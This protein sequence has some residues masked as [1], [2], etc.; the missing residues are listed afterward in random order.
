MIHLHRLIE[1]Q[2]SGDG[3]KTAFIS[4]K[5]H[6]DYRETDRITKELA[7]HL[8][9]QTG[10]RDLLALWMPNSPE[11]VFAYLAAFRAYRVPMPIHFGST[12]PEVSGMLA[13]AGAKHLIVAGGLAEKEAEEWFA[14]TSIEKLWTLENYRLKLLAERGEKHA[15]ARRKEGIGQNTCLILHTSGSSG[16]SKGVVLSRKSISHVIEGRVATACICYDSFAVVA[17]SLSHSVGLYQVLALLSQGASFELLSGYDY[18]RM[19]R[20][21]NEHHPSH[22]IMVVSAFSQLLE[23]P[24]INESSFRNIVFASVGADR[25]TRKV[26]NKYR[27]LTGEFLSVSYGMT[28]YSWILVNTEKNPEH[29]LALGRPTKSTRVELRDSNGNIVPQGSTGEIFV[30]GGNTMQG[31]LN[32]SDLD[33]LTI[34]DGWIRSGD[35]AYQDESGSYWFVGRTT[36]LIVLSSGDNVSPAEIENEI[37]AFPGI[38]DC[39]VISM[40]DEKLDSE[41]SWAFM[42]CDKVRCTP[43]DA[44][45][46]MKYLRSRLSDY[47]LPSRLFFLDKLPT[48]IS[49]KLSRKKMKQWCI[50][51]M[52][53]LKRCFPSPRLSA[54]DKRDFQ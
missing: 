50:R 37:L 51:N 48:G 33:N 16:Q 18:D 28:E 3:S 44:D 27:A 36:D 35:L 34:R 49:G 54:H 43:D 42:T 4:G 53:E 45:K 24:D 7:G 29:I 9:D 15:P 13:N 11:L 6:F 39:I 31:Y 21:I 2:T 52:A 41:V 5:D 10:E 12:I 17:S 38:N 1:P 22:L 8:S 25:V 46:I 32:R 19:A 23:H 20:S 47:K 14:G 40:H 26:Q 30:R